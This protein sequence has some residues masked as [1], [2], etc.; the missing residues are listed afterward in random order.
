MMND[1]TIVCS[2]DIFTKPPDPEKLF[3][4]YF[5]LYSSGDKNKSTNDNKISQNR[6]ITKLFVRAKY[7]FTCIDDIYTDD[8]KGLGTSYF[9]QIS[10]ERRATRAL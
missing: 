8:C 3:I 5:Y 1:T 9:L 4:R 10:G 2:F 6:R 7:I